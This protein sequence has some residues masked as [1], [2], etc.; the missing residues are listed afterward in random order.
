[1]NKILISLLIGGILL[2]FGDIIIKKWSLGSSF[3]FYIIAMCF[4]IAAL[5]ILGFVYKTENMA[6]ASTIMVTFNC[7]TLAILGIILYKETFSIKQIIGLVFA[8]LSVI[9]LEL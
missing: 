3:V 5:T 8:I 2:T 6:I 4:Y 9:F 7:L 1:M